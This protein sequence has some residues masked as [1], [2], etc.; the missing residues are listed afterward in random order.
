[1]ATSLVPTARGGISQLLDFTPNDVEAVRNIIAPGAPDSIVKLVLY[2]S[3][4]LGCDP[5]GKN[6]YAINRPRKTGKGPACPK[7]KKSLRKSKDEGQG[8]YCW[9]KQ[10]G[11]GATFGEDHF[12]GAESDTE[13]NWVLQSSIDLFRSIA[14]SSDGYQ[15]QDGPFWCGPDGKWVDVW[16]GANAPAA[17]RVGILR[18]SFAQPLYTVARF[19]SYAQA[20]GD[21]KPQGLWA[22]MPEVMIAK[23]AEALAIRRAFPQKLS[24]LYI[25]EEMDQADNEPRNITPTTTPT[26]TTPS[27]QPVTQILTAHAESVT[28]EEI[29]TQDLV[30]LH[31][32]DSK[33]FVEW[34]TT[35]VTGFNG[36]TLTP[37]QK[38]EA[39]SKL[40]RR[41]TEVAADAKPA[42]N[43]SG[44]RAPEVAPAAAPSHGTTAP[45]AA[46]P[47]WDP[48]QQDT[49][50]HRAAVRSTDDPEQFVP[51][52]TGLTG[53]ALA[54]LIAAVKAH[55][56][57]RKSLK[58]IVDPLIDNEPLDPQ[59][60]PYVIEQIVKGAAA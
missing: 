20:S 53:T 4:Q 38:L 47:L 42:V 46:T 5:L 43:G 54:A 28:I 57:E 11:C 40:R 27:A 1:M 55:G 22:K 45:S 8:W 52:V 16:L 39:A 23:C 2:R 6:I 12:A 9:A 15:G 41:Q 29:T 21:G 50:P 13:D 25:A 19:S 31:G 32:G 10:G 14:E 49:A 36:K 58:R 24:G 35:N 60:V 37:K 34:A 30:A 56:V 3:Q 44:V 59:D 26:V 33:A 48:A 17:A 7:C 51:A 18:A